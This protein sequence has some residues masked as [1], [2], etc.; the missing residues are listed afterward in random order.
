MGT[1]EWS[2]SFIKTM[3]TSR[4][5]LV[6]DDVTFLHVKPLRLQE[7]FVVKQF[8][9]LYDLLADAVDGINKV[10]AKQVNLDWN[11]FESHEFITFLSLKFVDDRSYYVSDDSRSFHGLSSHES[12]RL[13]H[14]SWSLY[15]IWIFGLDFGSCL[16]KNPCNLRSFWSCW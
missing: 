6:H 1:C 12:V 16:P 8:G 13:R 11:E 10:F 5:W 15:W 9:I 2:W 7:K 4:K 14:K 3:F